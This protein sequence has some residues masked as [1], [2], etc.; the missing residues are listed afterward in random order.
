VKKIF[1]NKN[2]LTYPNVGYKSW[3]SLNIGGV[4]W[5]IF[6]LKIGVQGV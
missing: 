1:V 2:W 4:I 3:S 5:K 6:R